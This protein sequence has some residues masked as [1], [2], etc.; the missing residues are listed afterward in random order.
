MSVTANLARRGY[1][2]TTEWGKR[3]G[4]L[5]GVVNDLCHQGLIQY[6]KIGSRRYIHE[7]HNPP[8]ALPGKFE[9]KLSREDRQEIGE[10][11]SVKA[12]RTTSEYRRW[13]ARFNVHPGTISRWA[14]NYTQGEPI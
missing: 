3:R 6:R 11:F 7:D 2:T 13:G 1:L 5:P 8:I 14:K 9:S 12:H 4:Y 10:Y